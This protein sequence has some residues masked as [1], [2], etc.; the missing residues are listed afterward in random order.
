M[1]TEQLLRLCAKDWALLQTIRERL[2][3]RVIS[4]RSSGVAGYHIARETRIPEA[5][6][7]RWFNR[8]SAGA[9]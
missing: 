7:R 4:M 6:I 5:N 1:P 3:E 9:R 2:R 8:S